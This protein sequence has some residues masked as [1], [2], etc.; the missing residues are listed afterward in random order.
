MDINV[1]SA[2][3]H[4]RKIKYATYVR[5]KEKAVSGY[6]V[7]VNFVVNGFIRIVITFYNLKLVTLKRIILKKYTTVLFAERFRKES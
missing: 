6:S 3:R 7:H 4:K 2:D 5:N 1:Q